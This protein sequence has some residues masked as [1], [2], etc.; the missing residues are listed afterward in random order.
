MQ[1][2]VW[3]V[4]LSGASVPADTIDY[5]S[6]QLMANS[7]ESDQVHRLAPHHLVAIGFTQADAELTVRK[8]KKKVPNA[9]RW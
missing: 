5:Y 7:I 6:Q 9:L 3:S 4:W 1:G 8:K 2:D